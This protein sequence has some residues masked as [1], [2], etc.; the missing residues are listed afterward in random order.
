[1]RVLT[2]AIKRD[3]HAAESRLHSL[4]MNKIDHDRIHGLFLDPAKESRKN[5]Y[6]FITW[7]WCQRESFDW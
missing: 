5:S 2:V 1:M 3:A 6:C 7:S 4:K